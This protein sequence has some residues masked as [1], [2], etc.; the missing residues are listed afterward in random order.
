MKRIILLLGIF[1]LFSSFVFAKYIECS[2]NSDCFLNVKDTT[3]IDGK[4]ITLVRVGSANAVIV[5]VDGALETISASSEKV[6]KCIL[7]KNKET[8]FKG[9]D[10]PSN[11]A[12]L[13]I[14]K[15][16]D[17]IETEE[18]EQPQLDKCNDSDNGENINE[19]GEVTGINGWGTSDYCDF[20]T[21]EKG[22]LH[23]AVCNE[24][25]IATN[26]EIICPAE[27]P[28]C[29]KAVCSITPSKCTDTD[30]GINPNVEGTITESR[31]KDGPSATDY[32]EKLD[33]K[34]QPWNDCS[35]ELCGLREYYCETPYK[36]TT[37]RDIKCPNGCKDGVCLGYSEEGGEV[38]S[39]GGETK[40]L[41]EDIIKESIFCQ[42]C[43]INEETCIPIGVRINNKFCDINKELKPQLSGE[44]PC[45]NNYECDSNVCVSKK[46]ISTSFLEKIIDWFKKI[47]G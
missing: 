37:W 5:D 41:E 18:P 22:I 33:A 7:I 14:S 16:E 47:F 44:S 10:S 11:T 17:C 40:L 31:N 6:I 26:I 15:K 8:S 36:T 3:Y 35:G 12:T 42:G 27:A 9:Y 1:L 19:A 25:G 39:V 34:M 24:E 21:N 43:Q 20:L 30:N 45:N 32:C 4:N 28:Y 38:E 23:E 2:E 13:E 29:N 46:C